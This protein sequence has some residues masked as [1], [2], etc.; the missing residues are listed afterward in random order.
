MSRENIAP[1]ISAF[2]DDIIVIRM[3]ISIFI[4]PVYALLASCS[5]DAGGILAA[6]RRSSSECNSDGHDEIAVTLIYINDFYAY[7]RLTADAGAD[8]Y[9][10][11]AAFDMYL[12]YIPQNKIIYNTIDI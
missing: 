11:R 3:P 9:A 2:F 10:D 6:G 8:A 7:Y 12:I 5:R 1:T 4:G